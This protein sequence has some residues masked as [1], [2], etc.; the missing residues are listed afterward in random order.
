MRV[1]HQAPPPVATRVTRSPS[2]TPLVRNSVTATLARRAWKGVRWMSSKTMMKVR[3]LWIS[4]A[5]LDEI[6]GFAGGATE[7]LAGTWTAS[8]A[9]ISCGSPSSVRV[10]S[11]G[12]RPGMGVPFLSVTTTS[13]VTCST[14]EGNDGAGGSVGGAGEGAGLDAGTGGS[15]VWADA[16]EERQERRTRMGT[17]MA[18]ISPLD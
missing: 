5:M 9:A 10:K 17:G 8:K 15:G 18:F 6:R 11:F 4:G 12:P 7:G 2:R 14:C 3:P 1:L 13:T 16:T